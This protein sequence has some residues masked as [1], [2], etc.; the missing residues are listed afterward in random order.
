MFVIGIITWALCLTASFYF[1]HMG[2]QLA[3]D[4]AGALC[5]IAVGVTVLRYIGPAAV[6]CF[7]NKVNIFR[8]D[9]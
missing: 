3:S 5:A 2:Q 9:P 6:S 1:R 4:I 7:A 8:K